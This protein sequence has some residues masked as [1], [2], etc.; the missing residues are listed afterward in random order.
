MMKKI[1]LNSLDGLY[2]KIAETM[3]LYAP[4]EKAG[5]VDF[6]EWQPGERCGWTCSR[7]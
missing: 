1:S 4:I 5:Q 3:K 2:R 6:Y 7:R